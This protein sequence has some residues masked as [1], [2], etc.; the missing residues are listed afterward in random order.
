VPFEHLVPYRLEL[1]A[2]GTR[3]HPLVVG[4][5]GMGRC[6]DSFARLLAPL[7]RDG[8]GLLAPRAPYP[9][10]LR[11]A[12]ERRIG[13]AW[14]VYHGDEHEWLRSMHPSERYLLSVIDEA[15]AD[16]SVDAR[17]VFLLG[18][19]Q[20]CYLGY[21]VA[22]R[23]PDRFAGFVGIGGRLKR[24]FL[25]EELPLAARLPVLILH[26]RE[27]RVVSPD[28]ARGSRDALIAAGFSNVELHMTDGAHGIGEPEI[29]A[30]RAWLARHRAG[31]ERVG[32]R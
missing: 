30:I 23:H 3:P 16:P 26:G 7:V 2:G 11:R 13:H 19:S 32:P 4:L 22:L 15:T 31:G 24:E 20:G 21:Y 28:A 5:H 29:D 27:D 1:P 17:H 10:E 25:V 8:V 6:E 14:Y 9:F 18:F 12:G